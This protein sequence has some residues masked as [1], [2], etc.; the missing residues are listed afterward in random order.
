MKFFNKMSK[1]L[2][3]SYYHQSK[4]SLGKVLSVKKNIDIFARKITNMVKS[5]EE[6]K[7][8][9]YET[10]Y[11]LKSGVS[12]TQ[13]YKMLINSKF[14]FGHETFNI[15][16]Q[17]QKEADDFV[18]NPAEVE[19]GVLQCNK[20]QSKRTMSFTLQTRSGDESTSVWARCVDCGNGW[21]E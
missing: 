15:Y 3:S 12:V 5:E 6:F 1:K 4:A 20:C 13:C 10:I 19:E 16:K 2:M 9:L 21:R 14:A 17:A 7:R 18:M 8:I 11:T